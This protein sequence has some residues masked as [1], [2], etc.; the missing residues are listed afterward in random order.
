MFLGKDHG[1]GPL[2][3]RRHLSHDAP[4]LVVQRRIPE[5]PSVVAHGRGPRIGERIQEFINEWLRDLPCRVEEDLVR[6]QPVEIPKR[7]N[8]TRS[9]KVL[10]PGQGVIWHVV[11]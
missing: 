6:R 9:Q 4:D 7:V 3:L 2:G 1:Q 5:S 10:D 8:R 11:M